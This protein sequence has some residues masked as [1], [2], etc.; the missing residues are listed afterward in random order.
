MREDS[1]QPR[2]SS[3]SERIAVRCG[4]C[5]GPR[6]GNSETDVALTELC[7]TSALETTG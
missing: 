1:Q 2:P 5:A 4:L 7:A 3:A 6:R